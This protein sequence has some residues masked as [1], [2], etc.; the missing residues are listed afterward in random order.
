MSDPSDPLN[1]MD[2][3]FKEADDQA[4]EEMLKT[5]EGRT[6]AWSI[7][8]AR[9]LNNLTLLQKVAETWEKNGDI[10]PGHSLSISKRFDEMLA[11][12]C[13]VEHSNPSDVNSAE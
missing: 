11:W 2:R 10:A 6:L 9:V 1:D 7:A 4:I 5:P 8:K 3:E 12:F 13:D